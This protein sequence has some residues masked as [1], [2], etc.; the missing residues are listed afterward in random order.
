[1][2]SQ[3][4]HLIVTRAHAYLSALKARNESRRPKDVVKHSQSVV[5]AQAALQAAV[6]DIRCAS[7]LVGLSDL[8]RLRSALHFY[9]DPSVWKSDV[10][11]DWRGR[12]VEIAPAVD[13]D[14]GALARTAL[15]I[16]AEQEDA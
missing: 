6:I 3:H 13:D 11:T 5:E 10:T 9:A 7:A 1:M 4:L 16:M 12:R 14:C 15:G 8:D 2:N